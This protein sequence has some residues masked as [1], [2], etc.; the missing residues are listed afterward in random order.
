MNK[1]SDYHPILGS[2]TILILLALG[3]CSA[4]LS[5]T[6]WTECRQ[7]HGFFYCWKTVR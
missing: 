4:Y 5:Y 3:G 7:S 6:A 1:F 2:I